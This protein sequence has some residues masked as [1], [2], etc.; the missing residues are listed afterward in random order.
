MLVAV[1]AVDYVREVIAAA[2]L[3]FRYVHGLL[4]LSTHIDSIVGILAQQQTAVSTFVV[5]NVEVGKGEDRVASRQR[6][7]VI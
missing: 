5:V 1:P 7:G 6:G 4:L 3:S 2:T